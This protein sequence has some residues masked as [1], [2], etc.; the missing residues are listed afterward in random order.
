M[1]MRVIF[2]ADDLGRTVG[3]NDGIFEAHR[4]GLVR[5]ATL[6][7]GYESSRDAGRRLAEHP[8]LGVGLHVTLSGARPTLSPAQVPSLVDSRGRFP[9]RPELFAEP[10]RD[11]V[12]AEVRH[13]LRM[14]HEMT[15]RVPTHFDS[16]HHSHRHPVVAEAVVT[17]ASELGVPVRR[18]SDDLAE[19]FRVGNVRST[20]SFSEA[21]YGSGA[22]QATL[23]ELFARAADGSL[24]SSVEVMCHPGYADP[25]LRAESDYSD[26]REGEITVLCDPVVLEAFRSHGLI[27][28]RFDE[29]P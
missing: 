11:E 2:N 4:R 28:S 1:S 19:R 24:G 12:L 20:D 3:I 27:N 5:S 29:L 14:F 21:F 8:D 23:V 16:H 17:L 6:M 9:R 15:R 18:S 22:A 10:R 7:V 26:A 25:S 13:Q